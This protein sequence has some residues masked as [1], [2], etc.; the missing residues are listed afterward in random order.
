MLVRCGGTPWRFQES[1]VVVHPDRFQSLGDVNLGSAVTTG[2]T[3]P[4]RMRPGGKNRRASQLDYVMGP[5]KK[6]K[7][8]AASTMRRTYAVHGTRSCAKDEE[9]QSMV[10]MEARERRNKSQVQK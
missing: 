8:R 5:K 7:E 6:A 3:K 1:Y 2:E 4:S 9:E 10:R